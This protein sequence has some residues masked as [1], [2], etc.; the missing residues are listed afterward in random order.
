VRTGRRRTKQTTKG[1]KFCCQWRDG[2]TSWEPLKDLKETHPIQVAEYALAMNIADQLTF[3]WWV[4]HV[5]KKRERIIAM[6]KQRNARY[7]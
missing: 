5:L 1:W 2:S 6:T 3:N 4:P 7:E